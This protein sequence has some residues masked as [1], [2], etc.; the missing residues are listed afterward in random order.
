MR[1]AT[2]PR[3]IFA[4]ACASVAMLTACA[5]LDAPPT[6]GA[7]VPAAR[8][9]RADLRRMP[10]AAE[11]TARIT[12]DRTMLGAACAA[13][14]FLGDELLASLSPGETVDLAT[15]PGRQNWRLELGGLLC[16]TYAVSSAVDAT[17]GDVISVRIGVANQRT[18]LRV[19]RLT[20]AAVSL[21]E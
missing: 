16:P 12:R 18:S 13:D 9:V 7:P 2:E 6:G 10:T 21:P 4:V 1:I 20:P 15:P 11:S 17:A 8:I 14:I 5:T 3:A 19:R